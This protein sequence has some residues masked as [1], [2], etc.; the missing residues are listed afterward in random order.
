MI[1]TI[2]NVDDDK[3]VESAVAGG[4]LSKRARAKAKAV[5]AAKPDKAAMALNLST[6]TVVGVKQMPRLRLWLKSVF[7]KLSR[8]QPRK[9]AAVAHGVP[10]LLLLVR[11]LWT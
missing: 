9:P 6:T 2:R 1:S 3:N 5:R 4:G 10:Y 8:M 11:R 7:V